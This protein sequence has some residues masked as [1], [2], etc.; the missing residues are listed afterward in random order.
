M[1][2]VPSQEKLSNEQTNTILE[3]LGKLIWFYLKYLF[4]ILVLDVK[5]EMIVLR[6]ENSIPYVQLNLGERNL[7]DEIRSILPQSSSTVRK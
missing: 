7:N 4:Y 1:D 3:I 2:G 5:L 6:I